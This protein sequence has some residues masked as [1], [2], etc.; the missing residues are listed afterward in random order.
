MSISIIGAGIGP[1]SMTKDALSAVA[2][3][4]ILIGAE[5]LICDV[6]ARPGVSRFPQVK[7]DGIRD[8]V[9]RYPNEN[10][11]ILMSGDIGFYSGVKRVLD[12][13]ESE[14]VHLIPGLSSLQYFAALLYRPWQG[15]TLAGAHGRD[16][17]AA[18]LV[19]D[20]AETFFLTSGSLTAQ[21]I[22]ALL[23][24]AGF[25]SLRVTVGEN[26]GTREERIL[27]G[28]A[29][30]LSQADIAPLSVLLVD[31]PSPRRLV[32]CGLPDEL[33]SRG[34]TAMTKRETRS[35]VLAKLQLNNGDIVYDVGAGTGSVSVEAALLNKSGQIYAL[36]RDEDACAL[37]RENALKLG[38]Y[39][40]TVVPGDAPDSFNSL[41]APD[42]AFVDVSAA[43]LE[44]VLV[45]LLIL[46]P[47]LRLVVSASALEAIEL[48][49][50]LFRKLPFKDVEVTQ[51][52]VSRSAL[53]G[54]HHQML[55]Q[56][57]VWL[58]SG[59]GRYE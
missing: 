41:P 39:N 38:A 56:N 10:I 48:S 27:V 32:S 16:S 21:K 3:A 2:A 37:I 22:C 18:S 54:A 52:S 6:P 7:A 59:V 43:S 46:N 51:L 5:R 25:G 9:R 35:V 20:N 26:L 44:A 34:R 19:R 1:G 31:N 14:Q 23:T 24:G 45:R 17:D 55:A 33:F 36:E 8:I 42:A 15:W 50:A 57:P 58:F 30:E 40:I 49:A 53:L 4:D 11:C 47:E 28:T 13:L 29:A 12:A